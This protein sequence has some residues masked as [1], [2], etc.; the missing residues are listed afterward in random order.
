MHMEP[1]ISVSQSKRL[2]P[3]LGKHV[4]TVAALLCFFTV[5]DAKEAEPLSIQEAVEQALTAE[6]GIE[7]LKAERAATLDLAIAG[8]QLPDPIIR[9]GVSNFPIE[10]RDFNREPMS[11][12][13]LGVKQDFPTSL[14][15]DAAGAHL[16]ARALELR[17]LADDRKRTITLEVRQLWLGIYYELR[18]KKLIQ[19]SL[20]QL[21]ELHEVTR[22]QYAV[23]LKNQTGLISLGVEIRRTEDELLA[24]DERMTLLRS[25]LSRWI[26][27][28][29]F[30][31]WPPEELEFEFQQSEIM[32]DERLLQ[33]PLLR[34]ADARI[35]MT[36]SEVSMAESK[37]KPH[38]TG[39]VAYALRSGDLASGE[40]KSDF[41]SVA[42]GMRLPLFP[43]NRQDRALKAAESLNSA[44]KLQRSLLLRELNSRLST[45]IEEYD[46][47]NKRIEHYRDSIVPQ[48]LEFAHAAINAYQSDV[49]EYKDIVDS[50]RTAL[51]VQLELVRL[52]TDRLRTW[53]AIDYLLSDEDVG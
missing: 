4:A 36:D 10:T 11:Q 51:A 52:K 13:K 21:R 1:R 17:H 8:R 45:A 32:R 40:P 42:I 41:L 46:S 29:A 24:T 49:G 38:L 26:H 25:N 34:A 28:D 7:A 27:D 6:P 2:L 5:S 33:H 9:L 12:L 15:R 53:A 16:N 18:A 48:A 3:A 50:Q 30:R 43:E 31:S 37:F 20:E 47:L 19:A 22:S 44:A 23:G 14:S 39:E 35:T